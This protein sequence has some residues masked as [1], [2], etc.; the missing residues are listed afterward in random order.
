MRK[1]KY[2]INNLDCANCAIE[3]EKELNKHFTNAKVNFN[4]SII[5]FESEKEYKLKEI[6]KI[7]KN[8]E[9][10]ASVTEEKINVKKEY[11]LWI[12]ISAILICL[13]GYYLIND[14]YKIIFYIISYTLFLYKTFIKAIKI[15]VKNK[16][17]DENALI[18]ISCIGALCLGEVIEGMMVVVLYTIGKILEE[19]AINNSRRSI[20]NLIDLKEPY[21]NKKEGIKEIKVSV[22][23]LKIDDIVIIKKGEKIPVDG[24]VIEGK[25]KIDTSNITGESLYK[26]IDINDQI[27]SGCINMD[28]VI[29]MKVTKTYSDSTVA[30]ILSILEEATDKKSKLET[31]VSKFSQIYTPTIILSAVLLIVILPLFN[32]SLNESIYRSLTFLVI[33]CPCAIAISVPL[34][35]FTGIG[36]A[37]KNGI[38]I[39]GSNYLDNLVHSNN[40][41]FDKTGTLTTGEFG[42]SDIKII[43]KNYTKQQIINIL[44]NGEKYSNHPIARSFMNLKKTEDLKINN[45]REIE[46]KGIEFNIDNKKITVGNKKI[47]SCE[48]DAI[49]HLNID[50][51]H[52]ASITINDGLKANAKKVIEDL[53]NKNINVHLLTGDKKDVALAIGKKLGIDDIRYEMLPTDKYKIYEEIDNNSLSIFVGDGVND[54]PVLKRADIGI[55]MGN[56]GSEVAIEASDIVIMNDDLSKIPLAI[57]ISKY[58]KKIIKQNLLFAFST[59]IIILLLSIFGLATM[60]LAVFADTGVTLITIINTLRI[61]NKFAK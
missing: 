38:L 55:S 39:K 58:T 7:V 6:N 33:S 26:N 49:L 57:D 32:I 27:L 13:I 22:E 47:C 1:Y 11:H 8:V 25:S 21:A 9:P 30:Q 37:S 50:G 45:F 28:N 46:G 17:V 60:Y 16:R 4:T 43:D 42:V 10:E 36:I 2:N 48:Y 18:T 31:N 53:Q 23:D 54:A 51:K 3:V 44:V 5:T 56:V 29:K 59:K 34:S 12:L 14:K 19:K 20:S 41:I 61:K 52:V 40:I 15:L 24:I 35:Y